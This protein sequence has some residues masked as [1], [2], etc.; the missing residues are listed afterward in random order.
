MGDFLGDKIFVPRSLYWK[1]S[2]YPANPSF[3]D[4]YIFPTLYF[5]KQKMILVQSFTLH[6]IV[7][8]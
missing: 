7:L 2:C 6:W 8:R 1:N 3:K 4:A 5:I